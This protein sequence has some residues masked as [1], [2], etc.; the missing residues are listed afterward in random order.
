[1]KIKYDALFD[2]QVFTGFEDYC[3]FDSVAHSI[4][5]KITANAQSK[6][7]HSIKHKVTA[8]ICE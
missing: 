1:M 7:A 6:V 8:N 3:R 4:K 2:F 5:H